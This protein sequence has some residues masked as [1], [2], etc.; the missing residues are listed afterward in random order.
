MVFTVSELVLA[1]VFQLLSEELE[2][3]NVAE[4]QLALKLTLMFGAVGI[5]L[6]VTATDLAALQQFVVLSLVRT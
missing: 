2:E 6:T 5:G 4:L 1:P 3:V